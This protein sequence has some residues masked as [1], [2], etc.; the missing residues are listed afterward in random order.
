MGPPFH[1]IGLEKILMSAPRQYSV[2]FPR[3]VPCI[4]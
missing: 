3:E 1:D 4:T 2:Q